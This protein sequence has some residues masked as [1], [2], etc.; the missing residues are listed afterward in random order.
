MKTPRIIHRLYAAVACYFWV[1]CPICGRM[2]GGH[3]KPSGGL[4]LG[5][6]KGKT[7]C[8]NCID[9]AENLNRNYQS[10]WEARDVQK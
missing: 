4:Y 10:Q 7:V 9:R 6:R 3:E 1:P 8:S 2:F 5:G